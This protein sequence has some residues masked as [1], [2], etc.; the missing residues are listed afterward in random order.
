M[1]EFGVRI[2]VERDLALS[3]R[4]VTLVV[5]GVEVCN[6]GWVWV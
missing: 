2:R 5:F 4:L 1:F 6:G 3:L